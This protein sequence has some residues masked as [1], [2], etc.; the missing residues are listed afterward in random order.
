MNLLFEFANNNQGLGQWAAAFIALL[1]LIAAIYIGLL[2]HDINKRF[3][4]IESSVEVFGYIAY[5]EN[6]EPVVLRI[7]N[8]G[9]LQV[10]LTEYKV[11]DSEVQNIPP[12]LIPAGQQQGAWYNVPIN[13]SSLKFPTQVSLKVED[14]FQNEWVSEITIKSGSAGPESHVHKIRKI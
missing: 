1:A 3:K 11:G 9:K 6:H 10:Y 4:D 7:T 2:Q 5:T 14:Q 13:F 8:V 12:T